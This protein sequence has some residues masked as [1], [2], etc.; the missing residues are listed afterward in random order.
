M[1]GASGEKPGVRGGSGGRPLTLADA[2][3]AGRPRTLADGG[4]ILAGWVGMQS[5]RFG[6]PEVRPPS[7][8]DRLG[9]GAVRSPRGSVAPRF[10][11]PEVRPPSGPGRRRVPATLGSARFAGR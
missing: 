1:G 11:R 2:G 3:A 8:P 9:L 7:D 10:G 6:R 4:W 5:E